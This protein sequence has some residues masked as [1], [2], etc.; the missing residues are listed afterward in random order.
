MSSNIG[1]LRGGFVQ[2][3]R[4]EVD[5]ETL[6][7]CDIIVCNSKG[8]E[9]LDEPGVLW[10]PIQQGVITWDDVWDLGEVMS[11]Q[12]P[13]R[14]NAQQISFYKN[15]AFWGVGDQA[16]GALLY[17]RAMEKGLGTQLPIDGAE[18][19]ES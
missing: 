8:Q 13:G 10:D 9:R 3:K 14:T 6:R 15:N 17:E 5:D 4:R 18:Y 7:R 19:R 12:V 1:L 11:G 16:I 2:Q